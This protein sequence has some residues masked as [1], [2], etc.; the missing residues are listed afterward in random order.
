M[1]GLCRSRW[2]CGNCARAPR[3]PGC[4]HPH[5]QPPSFVRGRAG[6]ERAAGFATSEDPEDGYVLFEGLAGGDPAKLYVEV[7]D[8]IF[9]AEGAMELR[10]DVADRGGDQVIIADKLTL[11]IGE[12]TAPG[13]TLFDRI[14]DSVASSSASTSPG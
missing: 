11:R 2:Q 1:P 4:P 14:G 9:G 5:P 7:S 8:E 12:R 13:L 10:F 6:A 3:R